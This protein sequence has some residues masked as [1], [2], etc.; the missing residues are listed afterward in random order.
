MTTGLT[1]T[2]IENGN[3]LQLAFDNTYTFS[4]DQWYRLSAYLY[5]NNIRVY[6]NYEEIFEIQDN[7]SPF[8]TGVAGLW[9]HTSDPAGSATANFD[10]VYIWP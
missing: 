6:V 8:Y 1:L 9:L 3:P 7:A 4:A 5:D 10:D 2:K